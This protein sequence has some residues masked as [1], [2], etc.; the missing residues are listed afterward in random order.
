MWVA[1]VKFKAPLGAGRAPGLA[2]AQR[3]RIRTLCLPIPSDFHFLPDPIKPEASFPNRARGG[4]TD[5]RAVTADAARE[6]VKK[7]KAV[8]KAPLSW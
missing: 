6:E 1:N 2:I 7:Q 5:G 3:R 8:R 4:V